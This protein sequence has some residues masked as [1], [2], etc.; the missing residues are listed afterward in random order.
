MSED[1]DLDSVTAEDAEPEKKSAQEILR[2][3]IVHGLKTLESP[4]TRLFVSSLGAG[5]EIGFSLLMMAVVLSAAGD[6]PHIARE[7]LVA[8]AYAIGF[9]F[10]I[11][12]RSE[13]FTEQTTLAVLPVLHGKAGVGALARLWV[14]VYSGNLIGSAAFALLLVVFAPAHGIIEPGAFSELAGKM[15]DHP[16]WCILVS[17]ILAGWMMGLLSWLVAAV[18]DTISLIAVVALITTAI[19]L[20]GLHHVVAGSAEVLAGVFSGAT[21]VAEY[22][23]FLVGATVGNIIGGSVFVALVKYGHAI[24]QD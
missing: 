4:P 14:T 24:R 9:L 6:I 5:F 16:T 15:T 10:V 1:L 19:G 3:E 21:P 18:R 11:L 22:G 2:E 17:A 23:R 12:G 13:L 8:S 7:L 20:A